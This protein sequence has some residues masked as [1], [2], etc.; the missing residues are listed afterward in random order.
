MK[1]TTTTTK[2][3]TTDSGKI[4]TV[5]IERGTWTYDN[6]LDGMVIGQTT[7]LINRS[8]I[9]IVSVKG[10]AT[11]GQTPA[12]LTNHDENAPAGAYAYL[13]S[14]GYLSEYMYNTIMSLIA[15]TEAEA[16]I[17]Q[18]DL[19]TTLQAAEVESEK[20]HEAELELISKMENK[21]NQHNGWCNECQSYCYGDCQS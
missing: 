2:S 5:S 19:Y 3:V 4:I 8:E 14:A 20:R 16:Q 12:K 18:S 11:S 17:S 10:T 21:R 13:M 7:D 1:N 15:E 9:T 6:T